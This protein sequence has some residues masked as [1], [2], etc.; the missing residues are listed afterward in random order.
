M[1]QSVTTISEEKI[2]PAAVQEEAPRF[3]RRETLLTMLSVLAVMLLA[4]LDQ[5]IVG[6]AMPRV[7]AELQGFDRLT[8][9]TTVYLLASTVMVPIYGKLSDMYGR[10]PVF[11]FG[12]VVFLLGSGLSGAAQSMDQLIIFRALQGLGAGALMPIAMAVVGDLFTP[13]ERARWQGITGAVFGLSSIIGPAVGGWITD[14]ASGRWVFY[15]NLP[16]GLIALMMLIFVMPTLK[17]RAKDAKIDYIGAALLVV[18]TIPLLLGFTWA[19]S[20]Y[21]WVSVQVLG[22]FGVAV[23]ALVGFVFYEAWLSRRKGQPI[24]EPSLFKNQVF[25]ISVLITMISSIALFGSIYFLPFFVQGVLGTSITGSGLVLTPMMLA[26]IISSVISG[27]IV[28]A[29]GKYKWLAIAGAAISLG[30][31]ALLLRLGL[32]ST[33]FDVVL[34]MIVLGIGMGTGMSL[35]TLIVQNA[36]P[37]RIGQATATLTF[38]RSIGGV[39]ALSVMGSL[40]NSAYLPAF[41]QALPATVKQQIPAQA[42]SAFNNPQILLSPEAQAQVSHQFAAMGTQGQSLYNG[43]I[44]AVK[45]GLSQGLQGVFF[46]SLVITAI[47]LVAVFFLK[48]IELRGGKRSKRTEAV[49]ATEQAPV[50]E[51]VQ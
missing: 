24:I 26:A 41:Q 6:T 2:K 31:T 32:G 10:K 36:M 18:G 35:Y 19:G 37:T 43:L 13:R 30:G 38:F 22:L 47:G 20:Q 14:N 46:I 12:L 9:V 50:S 5:T 27:Q 8:W 39:I 33:N 28:A 3:S 15:V 40:L 23:V 45:T 51:V 44:E 25:A 42:L 1:S 49:A 29:T 21:E 34:A 7:I 17:G 4:S 16:I 48:E 11:I